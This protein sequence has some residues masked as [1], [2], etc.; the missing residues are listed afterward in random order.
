MATVSKTYCDVKGCNLEAFHKDKTVGVVFYTEQTEGRST[1]PYLTGV[2]L[3]FC[4]EHYQHYIDMFQFI[5]TGAQGNN[6]YTFKE[7][8]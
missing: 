4:K 6:T 7:Q 8:K 5:A 2:K 1:T 3:D